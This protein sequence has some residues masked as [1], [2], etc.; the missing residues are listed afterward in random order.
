MARQ[1]LQLFKKGS[2]S[3]PLATCV[4]ANDLLGRLVGLLSHK[5]LRAHEGLILEPCKQVHTLFM[6]F[7]ID[8]LFLSKENLVVGIEELV[9]WR[10]SKLHFKARK[11]IEVP[12]GS[13][14]ELGI[15][16]GDELE[17]RSC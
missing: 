15:R 2:T 9:P 6:Q 3:A 5:E 14:R 10:F 1:T 16:V 7:P 4:L 13:C 8:A 12:Y 11:V 17:L